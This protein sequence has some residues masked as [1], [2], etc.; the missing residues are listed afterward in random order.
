[1]WEGFGFEAVDC[2]LRPQAYLVDRARPGSADRFLPL[3]SFYRAH[4][5]DGYFVTPD[6]GHFA[7]VRDVA[8]AAIGVSLVV[9]PS[10]DPNAVA[11]AIDRALAA[12]EPIVAP[13]IARY[14]TAPDAYALIDSHYYLV[15]GAAGEDLVVFDSAHTAPY[16]RFD[17]YHKF[18][19]PRGEFVSLVEAFFRTSWPASA[20]REPG[21]WTIRAAPASDTTAGT[22]A[23]LRDALAAASSPTAVPFDRRHLAELRAIDHASP[24]AKKEHRL[25]QYLKEAHLCA[26]HLSMLARALGAADFAAAVEDH[27]ATTRQRRE[28]LMVDTLVRPDSIDWDAAG[29]YFEAERAGVLARMRELLET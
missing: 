23:C 11:A 9:E 16:E 20:L 7:F 1:M 15:L 21:L 10:A 29:A 2:F 27:V 25:K 8:P 22:A 19:I 28:R 17:S 24:R 6:K 12:E 14:A 13:A 5:I 4:G 18:R 3:L 26:L